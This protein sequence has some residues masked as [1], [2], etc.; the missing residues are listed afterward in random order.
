MPEHTS[1]AAPS[2]FTCLTAAT[3]PLSHP[4]A[5]LQKKN[6]ERLADALEKGDPRTVEALMS[7]QMTDDLDAAYR[8]RYLTHGRAL[9]P[10]T[11]RLCDEATTEDE[12]ERLEDELISLFQ[13]VRSASHPPPLPGC[14]GFKSLVCRVDPLLPA[15]SPHGTRPRELDA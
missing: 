6:F 10:A 13:D 12:Q 15:A 1:Y 11:A 8:L 7:M 5:G 9:D 3:H 2:V 14:A 4:I